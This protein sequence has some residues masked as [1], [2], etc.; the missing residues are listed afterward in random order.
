MI[1]TNKNCVCVCAWKEKPK[2]QA[3]A[4][5]CKPRSIFGSTNGSIARFI[6]LFIEYNQSI[7]ETGTF[8]A[9]D[10]WFWSE[11]LVVWIFFLFFF[12]RY[13]IHNLPNWYWDWHRASESAP[14]G[15]LFRKNICIGIDE[16]EVRHLLNIITLSEWLLG[17]LKIK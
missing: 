1:R 5:N 7:I 4:V 10:D 14:Y 6:G 11:C 2:R 3:L 16:T 13:A 15:N 8:W 17:W 12:L 9:V